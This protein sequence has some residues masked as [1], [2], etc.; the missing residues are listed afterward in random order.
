MESQ[1][2][3]A[4]APGGSSWLPHQQFP[5]A[6]RLQLATKS[7]KTFSFWEFDQHIKVAFS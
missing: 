4:A 7:K 2:A 3:F 5:Y 6:A 1:G